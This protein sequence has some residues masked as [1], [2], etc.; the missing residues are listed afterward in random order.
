MTNYWMRFV[1]ILKPLHI[2]EIKFDIQGLDRFF[3]ML[4]FRDAY[5]WCGYTFME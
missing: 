2:I 4:D 5:D 3:D 1:R